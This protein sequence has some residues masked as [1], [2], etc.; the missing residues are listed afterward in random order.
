MLVALLAL[1][2]VARVLVPEKKRADAAR[3]VDAP[4]CG[5]ANYSTV[6]FKKNSKASSSTVTAWLNARAPP[7]ARVV[8]LEAAAFDPRCA[9]VLEAARH[10]LVVSLR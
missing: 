4:D 9:P 6:F 1:I 10:L 3:A 7:S 8:A 5:P 2:V